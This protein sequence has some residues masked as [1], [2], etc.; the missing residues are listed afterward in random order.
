[1]SWT[2]RIALCC[3]RRAAVVWAI[4]LAGLA[5]ALVGPTQPALAATITVNTATD[6]DTSNATCSLREAIKAAN[7]D[8]AYNG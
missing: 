2:R 5:F 4:L 3:P 6:E 7:T 1:M 8:A